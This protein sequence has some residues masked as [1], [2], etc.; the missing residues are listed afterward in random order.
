MDAFGHRP[1]RLLDWVLSPEWLT[2]D[3]ASAL[4]GLPLDVVRRAMADWCLGLNDDGLI[5]RSS[6]WEF[7]ESLA[8]LLHWR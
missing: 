4:S 8:L 1:A 5:N 7:L 6:L 2:V 3:D